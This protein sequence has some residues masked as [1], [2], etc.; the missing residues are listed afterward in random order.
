MEFPQ[1]A[2]DETPQVA[3]HDVHRFPRYLSHRLSPPLPYTDCT[4]PLRV[5]KASCTD[6]TEN[7]Q[8]G[9]ELII[10]FLMMW[11]GREERR[12]RFEGVIE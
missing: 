6:C 5:R 9:T 2:E 10:Y 8:F 1:V 11:R 7:A 4:A 12:K 3:M